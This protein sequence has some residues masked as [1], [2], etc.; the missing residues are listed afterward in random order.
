MLQIPQRLFSRKIPESMEDVLNYKNKKVT[1]TQSE[2]FDKEDR[3]ILVKRLRD[4]FIESKKYH[5]IQ[6]KW[7]NNVIRKKKKRER[8]LARFVSKESI[9]TAP[10]K[11]IMHSPLMNTIHLNDEMKRNSFAVISL[12]GQQLKVTE[13]DVILVNQLKNYRIGD[14]IESDKVFLIGSKYFT[15][16]GRP[17]VENAR[18]IMSVESQTKGLKLIV[19]KKK[20]RKGYRRNYGHRQEQSFLRVHRIEYDIDDQLAG[21]GVKLWTDPQI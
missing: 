18:V 10:T 11:L 21:R 2:M 15:L 6:N 19:L 13:D 17:I 16:L 9:P 5:V 1:F 4:Q 12:N 14:L 7:K 8:R 20:R 3:R